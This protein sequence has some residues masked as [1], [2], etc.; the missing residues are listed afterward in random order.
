MDSSPPNHNYSF[1]K[2]LLSPYDHCITPH[3]DCKS[4]HPF[5][6]I[7]NHIENNCINIAFHII[8]SQNMRMQ[9]F[10]I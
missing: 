8:Q 5:A 2:Q 9:R 6:P 7:C 10:L 1:I 3:E 4:K